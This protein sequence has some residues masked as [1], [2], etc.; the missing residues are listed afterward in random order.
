[1]S[2]VAVRPQSSPWLNLS[3]LKTGLLSALPGLLFVA[4]FQPHSPDLIAQLARATM[5]EASQGATWWASW[6]GGISTPGYSAITPELMRLAGVWTVGVVSA[7]ITIYSAARILEVH[8]ARARLAIMLVSFAVTANLVSGRI[9]F[10]VGAAFAT[11]SLM[12]LSRRQTLP[13]VA[14]GIAASLGSPLAGMFLVMILLS[15]A[16]DRESR[17]NALIVSV[18][19]AV[20]VLV[21]QL[22]YPQAGAMPMQVW[23]I[24]LGLTACL[25]MWLCNPSV[26]LK[27]LTVLLAIAVVFFTIVDTLV[28][29]NIIRL[30][31]L[32]MAAAVAVSARAHRRLIAGILFLCVL[33]ICITS[34]VDLFRGQG[35]SFEKAFY[36]PL[37][38]QL[39]TNG[40][41][42]HRVEVI[43]PKTHGPALYVA[44][45][46]PIARGWERQLDV[47][48]N[49]IFYDGSL[50]AETYRAWL[51]Q[52][53]VK[54]VALPN[55]PL[56]YASAKEGEL[57]RSGLP[58]LNEVWSNENWH[59]YEVE[60]PS[61]LVSGPAV[62][63]QMDVESI[64]FHA[65]EAGSGD[66]KV[67][68]A[69]S[70]RLLG[71]DGTVF[72]G[73]IERA[74]DHLRY[75]VPAAGTYRLSAVTTE[76]S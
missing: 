46:L 41:A 26:I 21:T 74:G 52:L 9:T 70:L 50:N 5:A 40:N 45:Q 75:S 6:Y 13:A 73:E 2:N 37:L 51:D 11:L 43:D 17:P 53:A 42:T 28:G 16:V 8:I 54:W 76:D 58:Y 60:N 15:I 48:R 39:P 10:A 7:L 12:Y 69:R 29:A 59:L 71:I 36:S 66:I 47:T 24:A 68:W 19:A 33:W 64:T 3:V 65:T 44:P 35:Q 30:P 34:A 25:A 22:L 38:E 14:F 72:D 23:D 1:M 27:R 32:F 18:G 67:A 56:D 49:A 55:V 62:V 57:V 4:I 61:P 31:M 63:Q 20:P